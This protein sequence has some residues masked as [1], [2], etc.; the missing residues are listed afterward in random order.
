MC[1]EISI[2]VVKLGDKKSIGIEEISEEGDT[3]DEA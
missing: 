3:V 1:Y 2:W